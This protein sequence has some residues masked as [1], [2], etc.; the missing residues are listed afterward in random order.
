MSVA[1]VGSGAGQAEE[2]RSW[3]VTGGT[4]ESREFAFRCGEAD[5]EALNFAVPAVGVGFADPFGQVANDLYEPRPLLRVDAK[6]GQRTQA[7][8]WAQGVP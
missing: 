7:C 8:S 5:G 4:V 3:V 2:S 6:Q 1:P